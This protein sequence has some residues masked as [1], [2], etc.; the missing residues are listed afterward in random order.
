M[1]MNI[2][3]EG[4][5][6]SAY[7]RSMKPRGMDGPVDLFIFR[8]VGFV[9][10]W[11]LS[12]TRASPNSVTLISVLLGLAAGLSALPGTK[13]AFLACAVLFQ[14]SN[15]F[16]CADGQLAR[17]SGRHSPEGRLVDGVADYAVNLLVLAG[18]L[19]GLVHSGAALGPTLGM[20]A[21]GGLAAA[22]SCL[23]YDR[24][25]TRFAAAVAGKPDDGLE[26][27]ESARDFMA[28]TKGSKRAL[29]TVYYWYL[30]LQCDAADRARRTRETPGRQP[31]LRALSPCEEPLPER[32]RSVYTE[33]M[34]PILSLWS[35]TGP[36]A[37]V[38]YF[39]A[40]AIA[41]KIELYFLACFALA[42]ATA[43]LLLAQQLVDLK[44]RSGRYAED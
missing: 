23:Y 7:E 2:C 16:D 43:F 30:R 11:A 15:C 35:F 4:S 38:L 18:V 41:G 12:F 20:V 42:I 32:S 40:F 28:S 19:A 17:L 6:F 27:L 39:L 25:I 3:K 37:H 44:Y 8:P 29:W 14:A 24:A 21:G 9:I 22:F 31:R 26:E 36:S 10:A 5:F 1:T 13:A 33:A 34:L